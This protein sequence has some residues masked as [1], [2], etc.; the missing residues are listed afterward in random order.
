[1]LLCKVDT[2]KFKLVSSFG[3]IVYVNEDILKDHIK[4]NRI[5]NCNIENGQY[6]VVDNYDVARDQ[7]FEKEIVKKYERYSAISTA[8]GREMDFEYSIEGNEVR[9]IKYTGTSK[10]VIIPKF[11]TAVMPRAFRGC[12]IEELTL[13]NGLKAIGSFAFEKCKISQVE[14]PKSVEF[15]G[16]G[17]F[18]ENRKLVSGNFNYKST[19]KILNEKATIIDN[20]ISSIG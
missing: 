12:G 6:K 17:A 2:D 14:I 19:I 15:I 7:E 5:A 13:E 3:H 20:Y 9:L 16:Y 18:Y 1:M 8:L 4:S 10:Q 11:I